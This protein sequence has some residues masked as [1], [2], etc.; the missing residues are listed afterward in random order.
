MQS[1]VSGEFE[2]LRALPDG[3][4]TRTEVAVLLDV[5]RTEKHRAGLLATALGDLLV[6]I[7]AATVDMP[8][9]GPQLL[10]LA[11]EATEHFGRT[12]AP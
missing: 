7:G 10:L 12:E 11:E 3:S 8:L 1:E 2:H 6:A 4:L 9:T 5:L